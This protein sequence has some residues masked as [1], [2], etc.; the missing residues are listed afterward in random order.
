MQRWVLASSNLGKL[1]EFE[2]ALADFLS[3][4]Q[5]KLVNQSA[6]GITGADEP[7]DTFEDNALAKARHASRAASLP[8]LA[9][10]SGICV[11]ALGGAPGV[12]SARFFEDAMARGP[13]NE[14][15]HGPAI[16]LAELR[17]FDD[18]HRNESIDERNLQWLLLC[19]QKA[20]AI[21]SA[22]AAQQARNTQKD[23]DCESDASFWGAAFVAAIA[24]VRHAD[25]PEP[26]VVTARWP[27]KIVP[28]AQGSHGF[29]YDPIFF[30]P[31]LGRTGAQLTI[32]EKESVSHRGRA[33]KALQQRLDVLMLPAR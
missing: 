13:V 17:D 20:Y 12:R 9:D 1:R 18:A 8:A 15:A 25:D 7:H 4:H 14:S 23:S 33:L 2:H 24:F 3:R 11:D 21:K 31:T 22:H 26:I 5:I 32:A 30:D 28:N 16:S 29:G 10:D 27:G 6:L 19:M